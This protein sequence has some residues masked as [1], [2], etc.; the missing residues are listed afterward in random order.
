[1][2]WL[3]R[4]LGISLLGCALFYY[5]LPAATG[6]WQRALIGTTDIDDARASAFF[7]LFADR[8]LGFAVPPG[9]GLFR[10]FAHASLPADIGEELVSY[11]IDYQWLD[12]QGDI[13]KES[14]HHVTTRASS[15]QVT[16]AKDIGTE[17]APN[18]RFYAREDRLPSREQALYFNAAEL[19]EARLLRLR[20]TVMDPR[21]AQVGV[22]PFQQHLR[23]RESV[24]VAWQR[25][26]EQKRELLSKGSLYPSFLLSEYERRNLLSRYWRPI[27]PMGVL[28]ADYYIDTLYQLESEAPTLPPATPAGDG[29]FV[30]PQHWV[31][32][33][34]DAPRGSY[35][36]EWQA[37]PGGEA[38]RRLKLLWQSDDA[39]LQRDWHAKTSDLAWEGT[40]DA[41]LL[42]VTPDQPG[43][44]KLFIQSAGEWLDITPPRRYVRTFLCTP[45]AAL[46]YSLAPGTRAQ[47]LKIDARAFIR[48]G[49]P[50][51]V[52]SPRISLR[53][54]DEKATVLHQQAVELPRNLYPYQ[55]FADAAR[56]PSQVFEPVSNYVM[57]S[58]D[59][60]S[61]SVECSIPS[62]VS[63][64]S[65]PWRHPIYRELPAQQIYW[66]SYEEREPAWF[67]LL[68]ENA[69]VL[70][71]Q[72]RYHSLLWYFRPR[73][74]DTAVATGNYH[75]QS[76]IA[77]DPEAVELQVFTPNS[78]KNMSRMDSRAS[79]FRPV[80]PMMELH[81]AG[82]SGE[83]MVRP[84][85]VYLRDNADPEPIQ[86][87]IDDE[88]TL[89]TSIAGNSGRFRLPP[90]QTGSHQLRIQPPTT[91]WYV[92]QTAGDG[93]THLLR[94]A[95]SMTAQPDGYASVE[96]SLATTGSN[97]QLG[98]WLYTPEQLPPV[99]CEIDISARRY[100]GVQHDF[101]FF[102]HRYR[103]D[104]AGMDR[105]HVLMQRNNRVRGP[106]RLVLPLHPDLP[107]QSATVRLTC[108]RPGVLA[109][110]GLVSEGLSTHRYFEEHYA[111][112]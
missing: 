17:S 4:L 111:L 14:R 106:A 15:A 79:A 103:L 94:S 100:P 93:H 83:K 60:H 8:W 109:S 45:G 16:S 108:D 55:H 80:D 34:L 57:A 65:R 52:A 101:T 92:N 1:M 112:D 48:E 42:Q 9:A 51:A 53:L 62:L 47:P 21:I 2:R 107:A 56:L 40:L 58:P 99:N 87:W 68:P 25:L 13:L 30:G 70:I 89:Q 81:I 27:G 95:W 86:V 67:S 69:R 38:P 41:G 102:S 26:S 44:M 18:T 98:L 54:L 39:Q 61:L 20:V 85:L 23:A 104:G 46:E 73:D 6:L 84:G 5:L 35:R 11:A 74:L 43:T 63:A 10:F 37:I 82:S 64:H 28:N 110:A 31:T 59:A 22:R 36:M 3:G 66:Y 77:D 49:Q 7:P 72:K 75:W 97:Q 24:D 90:V 19:S 91:Q 71:R 32:V 96:F 33:V 50:T 76:L 29:L 88:L 105:S 12:S 78:G